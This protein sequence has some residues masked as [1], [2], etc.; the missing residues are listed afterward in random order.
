MALLDGQRLAVLGGGNLG[1]ALIAGLIESGVWPAKRIAVS[2]R[3]RES[4]EALAR[5]LGI[6]AAHDNLDCVRGADIVLLAVKP[7][8]L[9]GVLEQISGSVKDALIISVAA[10]V[11]SRRIEDELQEG[12]RVVRAMPNTPASVK[13]SATAVAA[14]RSATAG[15]LE[16][17]RN[18]F[19]AIG[20]VVVI[21]EAHLD[22][23]T[24]LSGA[25][26]AYVFVMIEALA[27]AGVKVGLPRE[28]AL[29]L[30]AQTFHGAARM[31]QETGDHPGRLKDQVTSPGGCTIAGLHALEQGGLRATLMNAVETATRRA[32]EL[33]RD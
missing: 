8:V 17:S 26:P 13:Q 4:S 3:R 2:N 25:G 1:S 7:H 15:D 6:R 14:G 29:E 5:R 12:P 20:R 32:N 21:D 16:L 19:E 9:P 27:D 23:V 24:A 33:G 11:P 18:I 10:G 28:V 30:A 31:L 22:A